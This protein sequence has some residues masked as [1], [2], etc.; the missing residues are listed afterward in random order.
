MCLYP[1][2]TAGLGWMSP[3]PTWSATIW[4]VGRVSSYSWAVWESRLH[5]LF[6]V[7]V[8]VRLCFFCHLWMGYS[9]QNFFVLLGCPF[10]SSLARK[11]RLF[12]GIFLV[13]VY[14]FSGCQLSSTQ[15]GHETKREYW[16]L[17][18]VLFSESRDLTGLPSSLH[19]LMF[20]VQRFYLCL[21]GRIGSSTFTPSWSR[22][23]RK[24]QFTFFSFFFFLFT[25]FYFKIASFTHF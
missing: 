25:L 17:T 1:T 11:T 15:H 23:G 12:L 6:A 18:D 20:N 14:Y 10:P 4:A 19:F 13:C 2:M 5:S 22:T 16:K 8:W 24:E 3:L 7:S 21:V 9:Y